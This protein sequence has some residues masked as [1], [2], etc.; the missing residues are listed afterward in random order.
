[1]EDS[2]V[3]EREE[4]LGYGKYDYAARTES[5]TTNSRNGEFE[6]RLVKRNETT[7]SGDIEEKIISMYAKGMTTNDISAHIEDI[8]GLEVSDSLVS[9]ITDKILPVVKEW[10]QRPLESIYAVVFMDAIHYNV[11]CEGRIVKKA[12]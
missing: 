1:M 2:L 4:T 3:A 5:G 12:V 9:R 6:P 7:L 8:Y 11:R 10:Q